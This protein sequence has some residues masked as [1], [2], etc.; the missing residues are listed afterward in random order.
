MLA[1]TLYFNVWW[2]ICGLNGILLTYNNIK[3]QLIFRK[4]LPTRKS[5]RELIDSH[6]TIDHYRVQIYTYVP[7][8]MV[9]IWS[10]TRVNGLMESF[11]QLLKDEGVVID[12]FK[13][14]ESPINGSLHIKAVN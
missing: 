11:K 8:Y 10:N 9:L 4:G 13:L 14:Y 2:L 5:M 1:K 12:S 3:M 7:G 6:F